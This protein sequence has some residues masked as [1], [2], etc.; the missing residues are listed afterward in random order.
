MRTALYART[1][2]LTEDLKS[3]VELQL[4]ALRNYATQN[5]M[6]I[7]E[8]FTDEG[9]SG[10][11]RDRS[12]LNRMCDAARR[13]RF[14]VLLTRDAARLAR[15]SVLLV[16]LLEELEQCGVR[17]IFL[18]GPALSRNALDVS[19][20]EEVFGVPFAY[21]RIPRR[22]DVAAHLKIDESKAAVVRRSFDVQ[23]CGDSGQEE[24]VAAQGCSDELRRPVKELAR[25]VVGLT[26][27]RQRKACPG[28]H[29]NRRISY[30]G[31]E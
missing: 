20:R 30:R 29:S 8:E 2:C 25:G 31:G 9:Y 4:E 23:A 10:L 6:E 26:L 17:T 22:D 13:R 15:N 14:E 1:A 18:E 3:A 24:S 19:N 16:S 27:S 11:K 28:L 21:V 7:V 5:G 12:G